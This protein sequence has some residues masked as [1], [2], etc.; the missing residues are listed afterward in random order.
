MLGVS[1]S[2]IMKAL[3]LREILARAAGEW[4]AKGSIY[5]IPRETVGRVLALEE[6]SP[7]FDINS[8]RVSLPVGPAAGPH[9]QIAPNMVAAWLAGA[10]VFE[11]KTVQEIGRAHV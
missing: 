7:G 5:D 11:L 3:P 4:S 2:K 1:V 10:R 6:E 8:R 9:T